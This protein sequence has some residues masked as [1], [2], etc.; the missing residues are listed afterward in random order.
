[1]AK[2]LLAI[3][4]V[5]KIARKLLDNMTMENRPKKLLEQVSD[6][7]RL[8][9]YSYRTEETYIQWIRRYILF[10][11]K[12][13]PKEMVVPEIEAFLT[14]LAVEGNV[15]VSTSDSTLCRISKS[16][17]SLPALTAFDGDIIG[18]RAGLLRKGSF[19]PPS[20]LFSN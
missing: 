2:K 18:K 6:Q 19:D 5:D 8:K 12:R 20:R 15:A 1:M 13:N 11:N 17:L 9:Y 7:I 14:H 4:P 3:L 10:H 16:A